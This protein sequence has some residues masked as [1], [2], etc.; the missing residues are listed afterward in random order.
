MRLMRSL[1]L[2][3]NSQKRNWVSIEPPYLLCY[4]SYPFAHLVRSLLLCIGIYTPLN[5]FLPIS[6]N[7]YRKRKRLDLFFPF[8]SS[9]VRENFPNHFLGSIDTIQ[10]CFGTQNSIGIAQPNGRYSSIYLTQNWRTL[11]LRIVIWVSSLY[12]LA[13]LSLGCR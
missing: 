6:I 1:S 12:P 3:L 10:R 5:S 8:L 7:R 11:K 13:A 4:K 2:F 9:W